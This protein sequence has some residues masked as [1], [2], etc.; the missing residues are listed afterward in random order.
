MT[1]C[2]KVHSVM[3]EAAEIKYI[4]LEQPLVTLGS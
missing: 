1:S 4:P 2:T 3:R